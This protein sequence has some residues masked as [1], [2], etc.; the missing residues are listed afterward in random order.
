M[1]PP[2]RGMKCKCAPL[3]SVHQQKGMEKGAGL[4]R[5]HGPSPTPY[6]TPLGKLL[7]RPEMD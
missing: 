2:A 6:W 7:H 5:W 3:P 4:S 1:H